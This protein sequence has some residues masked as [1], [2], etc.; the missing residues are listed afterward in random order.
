[1]ACWAAVSMGAN[2]DRR[3]VTWTIA[4]GVSSW[5]SGDE[6]VDVGGADNNPAVIETNTASLM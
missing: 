3:A 4:T 1:M 5:S 6:V 2:A